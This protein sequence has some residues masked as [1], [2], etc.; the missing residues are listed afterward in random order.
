MDTQIGNQFCER[1]LVIDFKGTKVLKIWDNL[2]EVGAATAHKLNYIL[3]IDV[4]L[5]LL[6]NL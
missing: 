1:T 2:L 5:E 3:R 4:K 6:L